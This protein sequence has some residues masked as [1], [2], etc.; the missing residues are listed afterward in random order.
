MCRAQ[1]APVASHCLGIIPCLPGCGAFIISLAFQRPGIVTGICMIRSSVAFVLKLCS[2]RIAFIIPHLVS[3]DER[4]E[5]GEAREI[6]SRRQCQSMIADTNTV[7]GRGG[8]SRSSREKAG[9]ASG[10]IQ[11]LAHK[12]ALGEAQPPLGGLARGGIDDTLGET[13]AQL[14]AALQQVLPQLVLVR[15]VGDGLEEGRQRE[16]RVAGQREGLD[17]QLVHLLQHA[18]LGVGSQDAVEGLRCVEGQVHKSAIRVALHFKV[19]EEHIRAEELERLIDDIVVLPVLTPRGRGG[20]GL[21]LD[22]GQQRKATDGLYAL[23]LVVGR[24]VRLKIELSTMKERTT[25]CINIWQRSVEILQT[26]EK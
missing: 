7:N 22:D 5:K 2:L 3:Q 17:G 13:V 21:G 14:V 9:L 16:A 26:L 12:L 4:R 25:K 6:R 15:L 23:V 10:G 24:V 11:A 8:K 20:A 18:V 1:P 19:L